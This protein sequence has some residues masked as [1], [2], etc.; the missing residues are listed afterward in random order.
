MRS[1]SAI[2]S[3]SPVVLLL[4][5]AQLPSLTCSPFL[6][7]CLRASTSSEIE[8][9]VLRESAYDDQQCFVRWN[10]HFLRSE[11]WDQDASRLVRGWQAQ[12]I[13]SV[14]RTSHPERGCS[15]RVFS[16]LKENVQQRQLY[17]AVESLSPRRESGSEAGVLG[18]HGQ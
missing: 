10:G 18:K 12:T 16:S 8:V 17:A 1:S 11:R 7:R 3:V 14:A 9:G 13:G 15:S 6:T 4:L 2:C 5:A